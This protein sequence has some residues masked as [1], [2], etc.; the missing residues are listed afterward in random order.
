MAK[1][2]ISKTSI[3]KKIARKQNLQLKEV[4]IKLKKN[5]KLQLASML[6]LPKRKKIVVNLN[7]LDKETKEG[8]KVI[9]PGKVLGSGELNHKIT[10]A[11]FSIS[12][13]AKSKLK[14]YDIIGIEDML[15]E[16]EVKI[17]R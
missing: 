11:A 8:E 7:K 15:K 2:T 12:K 6:A 1:M 4:I 14:G 9:V 3:E 10:L 13:S 5:N 16:K 17:I